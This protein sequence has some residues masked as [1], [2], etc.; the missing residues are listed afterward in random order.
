MY[1]LVVRFCC[2]SSFP[3]PPPHLPSSL[4]ESA[5]NGEKASASL[6]FKLLFFSFSCSYLLLSNTLQYAGFIVLV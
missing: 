4:V 1:H 5:A 6:F 2:R 3:T